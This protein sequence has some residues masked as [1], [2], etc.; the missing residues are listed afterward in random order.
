MEEDQVKGLAESYRNRATWNIH[1]LNRPE[2]LDH[3]AFIFDLSVEQAWEVENQLIKDGWV[4]VDSWDTVTF[5]PNE[6]IKQLF[7]I[8]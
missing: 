2:T 3:F 1:A 8:L 6:Y 5:F 4:S 7:L